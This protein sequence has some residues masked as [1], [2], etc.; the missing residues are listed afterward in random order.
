MP[1]S[2]QRSSSHYAPRWRRTRRRLRD[3]SLRNAAEGARTRRQRVNVERETDRPIPAHD[4]AGVRA[5][6]PEQW[7][8][9]PDEHLLGAPDRINTDT[10]RFARSGWIRLQP[11]E[12]DH[13][14]GSLDEARLEASREMR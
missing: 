3:S 1:P 9:L 7:R 8:E 11:V 10:E 13:E 4:R 6:P 12:I 5:D 2:V 14:R